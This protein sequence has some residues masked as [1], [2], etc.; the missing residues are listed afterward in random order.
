M[1]QELRRE[2]EE[3]TRKALVPQEAARVQDLKT[4]RKCDTA[5]MSGKKDIEF[6]ESLLG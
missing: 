4:M 3:R 6:G 2:I 5:E 1:E